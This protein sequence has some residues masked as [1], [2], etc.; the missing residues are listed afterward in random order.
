MLTPAWTT[1]RPHPQQS[2]LWRSKAKVVVVCSGRGSGK[3]EIAK[4]RVVR[5]LHVKKPWPDPLY[6][7]ALPTLNQAK[8]VAWKSIKRLVPK[9]WLAP[10]G[11]N[12]TDMSI[13]TIFGSTL[14]VLGMDKPQRVEGVQWDG[15]VVDESSD[16]RPGSF[17]L[18]ILP[19]L[20][21]KDAWCW[22][23][24]IPKRFGVGAREFREAF[25]TAQDCTDGTMEAYAWP[26]EDIVPKEA[27]DWAKKNLDPIDYNE[28]YR[29]RWETA[30][31][32]V[33]YGFDRHASVTEQAE[34]DPR[35]PIV[36]GQDFNVDP[37]AWT[38][39]Q[40]IGEEYRTFDELY[41]RH[42]HTRASLDALWRRYGERHGD[43]LW[44]FVGDASA[45]ARK[46]SATS[47]D[48]V[49][50][51]SD[52]RF[53]NKR[54]HY[55]RANPPV[56]DRFAACNAVLQS[57][58]GNRR[59]HIHPRCVNLIRDLESR[60]YKIRQGRTLREPDDVGDI[61]HI[62]DAWGYGIVALF[63]LIQREGSATVGVST[64]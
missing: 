11:I 60:S 42:T 4:R 52:E 61:G 5:F 31:G 54:V 18:S 56:V 55:P 63:P 22:R 1:L 40:K 59:A 25:E 10:K 44:L 30:G 15:G 32:M 27:I 23:I 57:A 14:Y 19:A 39:S 24:G 41:I 49:Q 36:V 6:F 47:T 34:Y 12:E 45:R 62:T 28:Q 3:S 38:L 48:Y 29:A 26:S 51:K 7:Y 20:S 21:H 16:Q 17:D 9:E 46:T 13:T 37:M 64:V 33:F 50:V 43:K 8:R 35:Y 53:V 2:A 58:D